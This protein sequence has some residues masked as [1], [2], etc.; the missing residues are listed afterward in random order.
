MSSDAN[1]HQR[2]AVGISGKSTADAWFQRILALAGATVLI[3]L[4]AMLISTAIDAWPVFRHAGW[5]FVVSAQWDPGISRSEITGDYGAL[6]FILGTLVTSG[7]ALLIAVPLAIGCGLFLTNI[8]PSAIRRP[9][10][11][12]IDLLAAIPSVV[13]G[14]WGLLFFVPIFVR[15]ANKFIADTL[16]EVVPFLSG[17]V[18][19]YNLA[20]AGIVLAI[21]VLPIITAVTRE[22]MSRTPVAE[23]HGA[24][25]LGSTR[26][27]MMRDIVLPRTRPGIIGAT[28]LGLGRALGETIAVAMLIGGS[29]QM[30]TTLFQGGQSMAGVIAITFQEAAP[31][32]IKALLGV[33]VVLFLI[34]IIVNIMARLVIWATGGRLAGDAAV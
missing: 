18:V 6:S 1:A 7:I 12:A 24:Y 20:S 14:L 32:N 30:P 19:T 27:E 22:V 28:M 13:Y 5:S 15:P 25:A 34:T 2:P 23:I 17:P 29:Q 21:M 3:I 8:A 26:W 4:A 11:Y 16:G 31:E 33:G 9:L 10:T